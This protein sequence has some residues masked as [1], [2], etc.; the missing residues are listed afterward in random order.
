L[1]LTQGAAGTVL[2]DWSDAARAVS[3]RVYQQV[4]GVDPD[5]TLALT[6]SDSDGTLSSLP[7]AATL[8]VKVIA[9]NSDGD[10]SSPSETKQILVP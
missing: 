5:F 4:V 7:S 2:A 8:K 9:V 3:Y 10:E 1:I 6:V